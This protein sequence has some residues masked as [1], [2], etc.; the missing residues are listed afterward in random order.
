MV[1]LTS[2]K[3]IRLGVV[4]LNLIQ[5]PSGELRPIMH[6]A[7]GFLN[8]TSAHSHPREILNPVQDDNIGMRLSQ[9]ARRPGARQVRFLGF[10]Y[11]LE[12]DE[13]GL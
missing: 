7:T 6:P 13:H 11:S 3:E 12:L 8:W 4:I 2:L 10:A 9:K 5:N 1:L